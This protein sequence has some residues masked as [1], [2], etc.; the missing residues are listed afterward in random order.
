MENLAH[1][2]SL[3]AWWSTVPPHRG[4]KHLGRLLQHGC[5]T[6]TRVFSD[7]RIELDNNPAG[8]ELRSVAV[9]CRRRSVRIGM[10]PR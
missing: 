4:I 7:R 1:S 9:G 8:R 6:L 10:P 2:A 3:A 5:T